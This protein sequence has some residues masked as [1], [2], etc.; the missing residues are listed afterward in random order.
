MSASIGESAEHLLNVSF[1]NG[2]AQAGIRFHFR[3]PLVDFALLRVG[4]SGRLLDLVAMFV[5]P[6]RERASIRQRECQYL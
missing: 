6:A 3:K 4:Q 5:Q 1:G 2:N